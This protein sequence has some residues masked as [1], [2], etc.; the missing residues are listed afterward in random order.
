MKGKISEDEEIKIHKCS[1][2]SHVETISGEM[3]ERS[4]EEDKIGIHKCRR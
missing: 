2:K 4:I 1:R 3:K